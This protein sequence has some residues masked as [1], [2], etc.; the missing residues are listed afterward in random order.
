LGDFNIRVMGFWVAVEME[1]KWKAQGGIVLPETQQSKIVAGTVKGI[2]PGARRE[3]GT[4]QTI[5]LNVGDRVLMREY[6][7]V[8]FDETTRFITADQVDCVLTE[9]K[10]LPLWDRIVITNWVDPSTSKIALPGTIEPDIYKGTVY[11]A[12]PGFPAVD[13]SPRPLGVKAGDHVMFRRWSAIPFSLND[14]LPFLVLRP[15]YIVG[16]I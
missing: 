1:T 16:K 9:E 7:S 4:M 15:Q 11:A 12:G 3:D 13:G 10:V 8:D 5:P 14:K 2:G 6:Y